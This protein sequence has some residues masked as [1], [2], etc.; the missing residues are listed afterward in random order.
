MGLVLIYRR[1][2]LILLQKLELIAE[3]VYIFLSGLPS[4]KI[5]DIHELHV[6]K[7]ARA[8]WNYFRA[9]SVFVDDLNDAN[10]IGVNS[11]AGLKWGKLFIF[12][13]GLD[14]INT[15]NSYDD[16]S[17][18]LKWNTH[19]AEIRYNYIDNIYI[20]L[21]ANIP[22]IVNVS[23]SLAADFKI[24]NI[25]I[26][27]D[28]YF[29]TS[30]GIHRQLNIVVERNGH[31]VSWN[32]S[33]SNIIQVQGS[34][35]YLQL[36]NVSSLSECTQDQGLYPVFQSSNV[37]CFVPTSSGFSFVMNDFNITSFL[38][39]SLQIRI[40]ESIILNLDQFQN[41][42][43]VVLLADI[44]TTVTLKGSS[45]TIILQNLFLSGNFAWDIPEQYPLYIFQ[46]LFLQEPISFQFVF[47]TFFF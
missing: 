4:G 34:S 27:G 39:D 29:N 44:S 5:I 14:T 31:S 1:F 25:K 7:G 23:S 46:Q 28:V 32:S 37:N 40:S 22:S 47:D 16:D 9:D 33:L 12:T 18:I 10:P 19:T 20:I 24:L 45:T 6:I 26:H 11:V 21:T 2:V 42:S 36:G 38:G 13:D 8:T 15:T 30:Q 43:N 3:N 35:Y 17:F 41:L